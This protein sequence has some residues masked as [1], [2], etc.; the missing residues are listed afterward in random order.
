MDL[1]IH[2]P[3][4]IAVRLSAAGDDLSRRALEPLNGW[5]SSWIAAPGASDLS[6]QTIQKHVDMWGRG[7]EFHPRSPRRF[8]SAKE[9]APIKRR[10]EMRPNRFHRFSRECRKL[11]RHSAFPDDFIWFLP[12][13]QDAPQVIRSSQPSTIQMATPAK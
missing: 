8:F 2:T 1:A 9:L 13:Q 10:K 7:R 6:A 11:W 3:D 12:V 5:P 4:D